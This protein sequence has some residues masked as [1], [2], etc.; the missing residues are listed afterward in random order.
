MQ[1]SRVLRRRVETGLALARQAGQA[2]QTQQK[3]QRILVQQGCP[4]KANGVVLVSAACLSM[5]WLQGPLP[6]QSAWEHR[7]FLILLVCRCCATALVARVHLSRGPVTPGQF[8]SPARMIVQRPWVP[9]RRLVEE[10]PGA[11]ATPGCVS[12]SSPS[13]CSSL[14]FLLGAAQGALPWSGGRGCAG[15]QFVVAVRTCRT[16]SEFRSHAAVQAPN[17]LQRK[18][19]CCGLD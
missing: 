7:P 3:W 8:L 11:R 2:R 10:L 1:Q 15:L 13:G 18:A 6:D 14:S 5:H 12:E 17:V 4:P 19:P 9:W 16:G